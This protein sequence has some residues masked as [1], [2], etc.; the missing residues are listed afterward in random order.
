MAAG[1]PGLGVQRLRCIAETRY[2]SNTTL[3]V[4]DREQLSLQMNHS[5]SMGDIYMV[6]P[7]GDTPEMQQAISGFVK[8]MQE[9]T[10]VLVASK[11][12]K[13][14]T[15]ASETLRYLVSYLKDARK[16]AVDPSAPSGTKVLCDASPDIAKTKAYDMHMY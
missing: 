11:D 12:A 5:G 7:K 2:H 6:V 13:N 1:L 8:T 3:T 15:I 10:M 4:A 9:L 14:F 16:Q